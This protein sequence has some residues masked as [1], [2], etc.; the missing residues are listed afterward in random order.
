MKLYLKCASPVH[1]GTGKLLEVFD[2]VFH[3][4]RV[5]KLNPDACLNRIYETH[6]DS[7]EQ[8]SKWVNQTAQ[9]I[10][11]LDREKRY[12]KGKEKK[13]YNQIL[14]EL[15]RNFNLINFCEKELN[16]PALAEELLSNP[17]CHRQTMY[18]LGRP[19]GTRQLREMMHV[20]GKPYI[21]G[22]SLKGALRTALAYRALKN[23]NKGQFDILLSGKQGTNI[24]GIGAILKRI[25]KMSEDAIRAIESH[26]FGNTKEALERLNKEQKNWQKNIGEEVEKVVFGCGFEKKGKILY[27]DP[28]FDLLKLVHISDTTESDAEP[29]AAQL[30]SFTRDGR[31]GAIKSGAPQF[32]EFLDEGSE[33]SCELRV[34]KKQLKAILNN[35]VN[36]WIDLREKFEQ[37]FRIHLDDGVENLETE[38]FHSVQD[39]LRQFSAAIIQK[40]SEW[41]NRFKPQEVSRI[42]SFYDQLN[43]K[44]TPLRI[45]F[46]SGWHST[47]VGLALAEHTQLRE[48]LP[49]LI[50][51]FNLDL[52]Y[53]QQ[54][55]LKNAQKNPRKVEAQIRLLK[56]QSSADRFPASRRLISLQRQPYAAVGWML[57]SDNPFPETRKKPKEKATPE[58]PD[59]EEAPKSFEAKV[60]QLKNKFNQ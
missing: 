30:N 4:E 56:R 44:E 58:S 29:I 38:I 11:T 12:K 24:R 21:P 6:A 49:E 22:S 60:E 46:S 35:R 40:E 37:L 19:G 28:K 10:N 15:R 59:R 36:G 25:R 51:T 57:L 20:N 8:Y 16:D 54:N 33:F 14:A 34:D 50:Y 31:S 23:L 1:I 9:K 5:I 7:L 17:E 55:L 41:L 39:A 48:Y 43:N 2:Y 32:C 27:D 47:T 53:K 3:Q 13:Q 26:Q 18:A 42:R 45:G 52:I